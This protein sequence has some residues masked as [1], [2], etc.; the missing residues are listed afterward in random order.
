VFSRL[1]P[2]R[3]LGV[4]VVAKAQRDWFFGLEIDDVLVRYPGLRLIPTARNVLKLE[5][6][7]AFR[8]E[9]P[10]K[11]VIADS[12]RVQILVPAD[13]TRELLS[14][15][16]LA[17][18]IPPSFHTLNDGTLCLGSPTRLRLLMGRSTSVLKFI[19]RCVIPYL[20]G[21]AYHER[22]GELPFGELA[23]GNAGICEDLELLFGF[24]DEAIVK[25][26]V[27]ASTLRRREANKQRC[28]CGSR[29]RLGRCHHRR[30]NAARYRLGRPW[31]RA[32]L[33]SLAEGRIR[34]LGQIQR[35]MPSPFR[36][37][38]AIEERPLTTAL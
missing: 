21:R 14:V 29:V 35:A 18:R 33:E 36:Y 10:G 6:D 28:A 7:L 13:T 1:P 2:R 12:F 4:Q 17:G 23:H 34:Q 30:V 25:A 31:F 5:G 11:E 9:A 15:R 26:F 22:H 24:R 16:E 19:E 3:S 38:Q 20:Y 27:S 8:A 32:V 37:R